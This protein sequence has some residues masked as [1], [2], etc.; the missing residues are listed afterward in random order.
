MVIVGFELGSEQSAAC[1]AKWA[2]E[3]QQTQVKPRQRC[4]QPE[5]FLTGEMALKEF[6]VKT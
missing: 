1:W 3:A 2:E 5:R 4:H 6:C